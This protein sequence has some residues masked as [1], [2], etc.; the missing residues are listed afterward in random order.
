MAVDF[1]I[2]NWKNG[3]DGVTRTLETKLEDMGFKTTQFKY[4]QS[5]P[6]STRVVFTYAPWERLHP[7]INQLDKMPEAN[8]PAW[9]HWMTEDPPDLRIPLPITL[10]IGLLRAWFDRL[11]ESPNEKI[12]KIVSLPL[13]KRFNTRLYKFRYVGEY[14]YAKKKGLLTV[15]ADISKVYADFYNSL[16]LKTIYAPWGL[17]DEAISHFDLERDID[18]LWLGTRRTKRRS[19]LLDK[20]RSELSRNHIEMH[21]VDGKENGYVHGEARNELISR[22][23]ITLNLLP[24]WY[25]NTLV[26][27]FPFAAANKSMVVSELALDH[28]PQLK[29]NIHYVAVPV[30]EIVPTIIRYLSRRDQREHIARAAYEFVTNELRF[31]NS[32][33]KIIKHI[34]LLISILFVHFAL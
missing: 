30:K 9:I 29:N 26:Y 1:A 7:V 34:H 25:D 22:T 8:R 32:L 10:N 14:Y 3:P 12:Q 19:K 11:Y 16:G 31:E 20:I 17:V 4:D 33:Q 5:I 24:T 15:L 13:L 21:V 27:R 28:C 18:V 6:K 2:C 23:K